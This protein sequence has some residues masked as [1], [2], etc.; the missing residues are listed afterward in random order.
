MLSE[1][2]PLEFH[3]VAFSLRRAGRTSQVQLRL[4]MISRRLPRE[5]VGPRAVTGFIYPRKG[6]EGRASPD[7]RGS[8]GSIPTPESPPALQT[9]Q[10]VTGATSHLS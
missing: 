9:V 6:Q 5:P 7:R 1:T 8:W 2:E 4:G 3:E 10:L